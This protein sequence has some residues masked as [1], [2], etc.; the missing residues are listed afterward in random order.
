MNDLFG[1]KIEY[2]RLSITDKCNLGCKYCKDGVNSCLNNL[3]LDQ[4]KQILIIFRKLGLIKLRLTGGE[5]FYRNDIFDIINF[6]DELGYD[7]Y[8]TTNA[9]FNKDI[10]EKI[11]KSPLK[12]INISLDTLDRDKFVK[13]TGFDLLINVIDNIKILSKVKK[14]KINTVLL[15]N[16]NKMI[17]DEM[18]LFA[19]K[20]D[21]VIRFIELMPIGVAKEIYNDEFVSKEEVLS[22]YAYIELGKKR[23]VASYYYIADFSTII[24]FI[25]PISNCFCN[26]CN[27]IRI[28]SEGYL[29]N[30]L[31]DKA[32][33]DLKP[34]IFKDEACEII[35]NHI[36]LKKER[37]DETTDNLMFR[38]GG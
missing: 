31:F 37:R 12:G 8:I 10:L 13:L 7:V 29:L 11:V 16:Y 3:S 2:L 34:V 21:I 22:H 18:I 25:D 23:S 20:H 27:R 35:K 5:P 4:I 14:I 1:R 32:K 33:L 24:G 9:T 26:A 6:A 30:C 15:R 28:N 19:K 17:I 38:I 36:L